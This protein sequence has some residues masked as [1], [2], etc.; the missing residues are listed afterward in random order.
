MGV[1][2][3][4]GRNSVFVFGE[5]GTIPSQ[6][7]FMETRICLGPSSAKIYSDTIS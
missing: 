1:G 5:R 7:L 3:C 4:Q 6:A 2:K